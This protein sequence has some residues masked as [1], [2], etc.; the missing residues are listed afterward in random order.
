M[1]DYC[2][3]QTSPDAPDAI[4]L[5]DELEEHL[6]SFG[7]P[8]ES[9]HGFSV[10]KLIREGVPF[11]VIYQEATP[12]GC[13]GIKLFPD[14]GEIKRMF[15][16]PAW[17]GKGYAKAM[18]HHLA[19]HALQHNITLLRLETGIHQIPAIKLYESFGF[20]RCGPFGEYREDPVSVYMQ[21]SLNHTMHP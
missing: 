1:T 17:Q 13:G 11:F 19:D 15:I 8:R 18:L 2:I 5:I 10:E 20:T 4:Q 12:I 3:T 21:M 16:R 9:R 14:Y 6:E 7:Y